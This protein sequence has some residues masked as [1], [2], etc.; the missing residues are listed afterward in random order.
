MPWQSDCRQRWQLGAWH[1][2]VVLF[3]GHK[4]LLHEGR[5]FA[6]KQ[7]VG[8]G[9]SARKSPLT[10]LLLGPPHGSL[11]TSPWAT[12]AINPLAVAPASRAWL[13]GEHSKEAGELC[14]DL[15]WSVPLSVS[16]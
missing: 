3:Q 15:P 7:S 8:H 5:C 6:R 14:T 9:T 4:S 16:P 1:G 13:A 12:R 11:G 2:H 10:R